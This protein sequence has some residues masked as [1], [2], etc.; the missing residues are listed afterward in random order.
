MET[1]DACSGACERGDGGDGQ[2]AEGGS[3]MALAPFMWLFVIGSCERDWQRAGKG[4]DRTA[5][6][7]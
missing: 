3:P 5:Q 4:H 7:C 1:R 6:S 2:G